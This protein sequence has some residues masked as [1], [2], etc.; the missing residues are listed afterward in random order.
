MCACTYTHRQQSGGGNS[1]DREHAGL[2]LLTFGRLRFGPCARRACI[3]YCERER[4]GFVFLSSTEWPARVCA[5]NFSDFDLVLA[6][7]AY[8]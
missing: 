2:A 3:R 8:S 6:A 4:G 1:I 5:G 7:R